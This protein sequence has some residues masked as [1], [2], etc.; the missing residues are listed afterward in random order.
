MATAR[1]TGHQP[2]YADL[3]ADHGRGEPVP[4]PRNQMHLPASPDKTV[5]HHF[6]LVCSFRTRKSA[7]SN[8]ATRAFRAGCTMPGFLGFGV[9][10]VDDVDSHGFDSDGFDSDDFDS[11]LMAL[12]LIAWA[13]EDVQEGV[14]DMNPLSS[15]EPEAESSSSSSS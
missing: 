1:S 2:R 3:H 12:I 9:D 4:Q 13:G 5:L 14:S 7:K 6:V 10:G 11:T 8:T 15:P